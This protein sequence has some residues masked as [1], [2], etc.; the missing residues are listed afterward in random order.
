MK[1]NKMIQGRFVKLCRYLRD[2]EDK[3]EISV[4]SDVENEEIEVTQNSKQIAGTPMKSIARML[5][6][7]VNDRI[8][9]L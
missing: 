2:N 9:A 3:F 4:F 8:M 7:G 1:K 5:S 6:N